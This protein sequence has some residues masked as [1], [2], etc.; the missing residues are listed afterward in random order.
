MST[1]RRFLVSTHEPFSGLLLRLLGVH[2]E[3]WVQGLLERSH[4][5]RHQQAKV[6]QAAAISIQN[7]WRAM[8]ARRLVQQLRVAHQES[9]KA[10][11]AA[12]CIQVR[13]PAP[14]TPHYTL[15]TLHYTLR[16]SH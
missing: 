14:I 15:H 11:A 2:L 7:A 10:G 1:L 9:L 4:V 6:T 5:F 3:A 16:S 12:S 13:L 8:Q